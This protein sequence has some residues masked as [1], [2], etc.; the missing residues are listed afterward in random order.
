[1]E[2][3]CFINNTHRAFITNSQIQKFEILHVPVTHNKNNSLISYSTFFSVFV[4]AATIVPVQ[5][6]VLSI[7]TAVGLT[8]RD[9]TEL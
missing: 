4:N 5:H 6:Q 2:K 8:A 3:I 1:M 7:E 9:V